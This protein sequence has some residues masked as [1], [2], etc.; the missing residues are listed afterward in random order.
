MRIL[1]GALNIGDQMYPTLLRANIQIGKS[2]CHLFQI[3]QK[4]KRKHHFSG[5]SFLVS[6]SLSPFPLMG[7]TF[8]IYCKY[9]KRVRF[10]DQLV[11][12]IVQACFLVFT[13]YFF[14]VQ[15]KGSQISAHNYKYSHK[16]MLLSVMC[17]GSTLASR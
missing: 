3:A 16:T 9:T 13:C 7:S 15:F 6:S 5:F 11:T 12:G 2:E 14:L 10:P 4:T 17:T 8:R 1:Y